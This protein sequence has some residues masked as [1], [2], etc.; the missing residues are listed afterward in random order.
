MASSPT[1]YAKVCLLPSLCCPHKALIVQNSSIHI[2]PSKFTSM[3][4]TSQPLYK[5][6][7]F[8]QFIRGV[9][10]CL[11]IQWYRT[12]AKSA[13]VC[14][15]WAAWSLCCPRKWTSH[16]S[17]TLSAV[18]SP[19]FLSWP[20]FSYS[21]TQCYCTSTKTVP[22]WNREPLLGPTSFHSLHLKK[23]LARLS[24]WWRETSENNICLF[25][26]QQSLSESLLF[27]DSSY[28]LSICW[29]LNCPKHVVTQ[30]DFT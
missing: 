3:S 22:R 15:F 13:T 10:R 24:L 28:L 8:L 25:T 29:C 7:T 1:A 5:N 26:L 14:F 11:Q 20:A 30:H 16:V 4:T 2:L 12:Q 9:S 23:W 27:T 6:C 21:T 17:K 18:R 19:T